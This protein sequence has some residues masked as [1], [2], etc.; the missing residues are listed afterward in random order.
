MDEVRYQIGDA[1]YTGWESAAYAWMA[2]QE[3]QLV[4]HQFF[5]ELPPQPAFLYPEIP[6]PNT[7]GGGSIAFA[8]VS[9]DVGESGQYRAY[10]GL[11]PQFSPCM[12]DGVRDGH[13]SDMSDM[14]LAFFVVAITVVCLKGLQR[15]F[16]S[17]PHND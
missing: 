14:W 2:L 1:C 12:L 8:V 6:E 9:V 15:I 3:P 16:D 13:I 5:P 11:V 17:A 10:T 4:Q 7:E